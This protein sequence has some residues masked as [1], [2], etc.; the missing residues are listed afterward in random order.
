MSFRVFV[1]FVSASDHFILTSAPRCFPPSDPNG[2]AS[3]FHVKPRRCDVTRDI[4]VD[5]PATM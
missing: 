4:T 3:V 1:V 2:A 5:V